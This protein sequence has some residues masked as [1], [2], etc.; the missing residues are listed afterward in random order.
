MQ[1]IFRVSL[2]TVGIHALLNLKRGWEAVG[3]HCMTSHTKRTKNE[4]QLIQRQSFQPKSYSM[5]NKYRHI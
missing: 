4:K 3:L 2:H 1:S 5:L